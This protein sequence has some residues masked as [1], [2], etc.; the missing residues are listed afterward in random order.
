MAPIAQTSI[1][2]GCQGGPLWVI[3]RH[4]GVVA[5][6]SALPSKADISIKH[7]QVSFGPIADITLFDHFVGA[8]LQL[9]DVETQRLCGLE[10]DYKVISRRRL[11]GQVSRFFALK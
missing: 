7:R 8:L 10:I 4:S 3:C 11:D 5:T 9:R 1:L 2:A 6:A